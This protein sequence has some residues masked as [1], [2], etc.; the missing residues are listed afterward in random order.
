MTRWMLGYL[1]RNSDAI[2]ASKRAPRAGSIWS[3]RPLLGDH[4]IGLWKGY[5]GDHEKAQR[6]C[7]A[8]EWLVAA[9]MVDVFD[10][11]VLQEGQYGNDVLMQLLRP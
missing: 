11:T 5:K 3:V 1:T 9:R 7:R 4:N 2:C 6:L 10:A 8:I